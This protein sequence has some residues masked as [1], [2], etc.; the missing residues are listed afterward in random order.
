EP[1]FESVDSL[2][3][4]DA[5]FHPWQEAEERHVKLSVALGETTSGCQ[6]RTIAFPGRRWLEP[7]P[8]RDGRIAGV[9]VREQEA[10][11]GAI[12]MTGVRVADGLYRLNVRVVNQTQPNE[13][14]NGSRDAALLR[15]LVSAHTILTVRCGA[16]VSLLDP[17]VSWRDAAAE[18]R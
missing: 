15:S 1:V 6:T 9:L 2:R 12:E 13:T 10:I 14:D 16:F 8:E 18:C 4:G 5:V 7:L 3:I 11:A 17:P